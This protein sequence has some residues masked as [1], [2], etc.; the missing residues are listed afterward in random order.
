MPAPTNAETYVVSESQLLWIWDKP[1]GN[2]Y[3]F[4][5][6]VKEG[7]TVVREINERMGYGPIGVVVIQGLQPKKEYSLSLSHYCTG[8]E[9][10]MQAL[11]EQKVTTFDKGKP[12][13]V[14]VAQNL[15]N[16]A[17]S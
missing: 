16:H 10:P 12:V 14:Y 1:I 13:S 5:V 4:K 9:T 8:T 15:C 17:S 2:G 7:T 11:G 3:S 6:T